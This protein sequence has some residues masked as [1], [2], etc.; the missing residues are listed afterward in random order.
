MAKNTA[1]STR[2][3]LTMAPGLP[4]ESNHVEQT[5]QA[6][7]DARC[8]RIGPLLASAG[9]VSGNIAPAGTPY[10]NG[11]QAAGAEL[12]IF[13]GIIYIDADLETLN[14]VFTCDGS[15]EAT[16]DIGADSQ[17]SGSSA[18]TQ[19]GSHSVSDTGTGWQEVVVSVENTSGGTSTAD[20]HLAFVIYPAKITVSN[21]GDP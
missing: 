6:Q 3:P 13:R 2:S 9:T 4:I 12:T 1:P 11:D 21:L 10:S 15:M 19:T 17:A 8:N 20:E 7:N 5:H 16:I 18:N 14:W